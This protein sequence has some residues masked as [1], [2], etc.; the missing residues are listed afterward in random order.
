MLFSTNA[1]Q[2]QTRQAL[3]RSLLRGNAT[4]ILIY[5]NAN[6]DVLLLS[7]SDKALN[8]VLAGT[9]DGLDLRK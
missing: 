7:S 8:F 4:K 2:S 5:S 3:G 9:S 1:R 6:A